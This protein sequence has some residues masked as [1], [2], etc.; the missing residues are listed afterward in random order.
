MRATACPSTR[1]ERSSRRSPGRNPVHAQRHR[2]E[3]MKPPATPGAGVR[4]ARR[5]RPRARRARAGLARRASRRPPRA[6]GRF[7]RPFRAPGARIS[8][9]SANRK[10]RTCLVSSQQVVVIDGRGHPRPP[11]SIVAKQLLQGQHVVRTRTASRS[12]RASPPRRAKAQVVLGFRPSESVFARFPP[13]RA[14]DAVPP[15]PRRLSCAPGIV[16]PAASS[17]LAKHDYFKRLRMNTKPSHVLSLR[18]AQ[19][20]LWRTVRCMVPTDE[21]RRRGVRALQGVRGHPPQYATVKR[22]ASPRRSAL[23]LAAGHK[24][25]ARHLSTRLRKHKEVVASLEAKRQEAASEYWAKKKEANAKYAAAKE[26]AN[27][28]LGDLRSFANGIDFT[29]HRAEDTRVLRDIC[30]VKVNSVARVILLAPRSFVRPRPAPGRVSRVEKP[31]SAET[32]RLVGA[33][34]ARRSRAAGENRTRASDFHGALR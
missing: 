2:S 21:A 25:A 28:Q 14:A 31:S 17:A 22:A 27:A 8:R 9:S 12:R 26:A 23:R 34:P 18:G 6:S 20:M 33:S 1:R 16:I 7:I 4:R 10:R 5:S 13:P 15:P 24:Y 11:A 30:D 29:T 19:G 32:G 3:P